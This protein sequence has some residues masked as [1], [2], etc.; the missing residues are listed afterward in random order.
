V[1]LEA[2]RTHRKKTSPV[3]PAIKQRNTSISETK[4]FPTIE[5]AVKPYDSV[6]DIQKTRLY[7]QHCLGCKKKVGEEKQTDAVVKAGK[8][9]QKTI[10]VTRNFRRMAK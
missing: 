2:G 5:E 3:V 1:D 6:S 4:D 7:D 10:R 9:Q 8:S